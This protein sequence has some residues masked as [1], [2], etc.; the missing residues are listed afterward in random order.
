MKTRLDERYDPE[1]LEPW[2]EERLRQAN[3]P[4]APRTTSQQSRM[5][6]PQREYRPEPPI[7][8]TPAKP[9]SVQIGVFFDGTGN[10]MHNDRRLPDR[11]ITNV[12]KLHDLYPDGGDHY[13]I[14]I[15]GVGTITGRESEDGFTA[16]ESAIGMG[17]GVGPEG[18]HARIELALARVRQI[19]EAYPHDSLVTFDVFG[20]SRGAALAR[21]FVNLI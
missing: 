8:D 12:A 7:P 14:Y 21:H 13:P 20:F 1:S 11:D 16:P 2:E 15:H 4:V 19:L 6:P 3:R 17:I 9:P 10:N 18:A 5:S